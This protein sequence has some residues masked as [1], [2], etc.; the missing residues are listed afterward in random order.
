MADQTQTGDQSSSQGGSSSQT[1][2]G[3]AQGNGS[4]T[5]QQTQASS[6][7]TSTTT[8]TTQTAARPEYIPESHWDATSGKVKDE[9]AFASF[10]NEHVAFKAAED[11]K[12]LTLPENP[13]GYKVEL[14]SDFTLP[15]GVTYEFRKDDPLLAQARTM[16]HQMGINQENFSKLLGLYAG[17]QIATEAEVTNARNAEIAKLGATGP[18]RVDAVTRFFKAH[19]GDADGARLASRMFTASDVAAAEKLVAKFAS[20]GGGNFSGA[21]READSGQRVTEEQWNKMT[22]SERKEY[23]ERH[24]ASTH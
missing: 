6:G 10:I 20:Q 15:Q 8:Q 21:R 7:A 2:S 23:A 19:L 11:S 17:A 12:R 22:Y 13:D 3:S 24:S 5:N 14:P 4:Q 16:A 1:A 9:K 18:Q